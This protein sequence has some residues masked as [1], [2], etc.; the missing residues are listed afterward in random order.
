MSPSRL[1]NEQ[2]CTFILGKRFPLVG[3]QLSEP[4]DRVAHNA[5]EHIVKVLPWIGVAGLAGLYQS[6]EKR[7]CPRPPLAAC[8]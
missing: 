1:F 5:P 3:E 4:G 2:P 8:E 6:K 7:R